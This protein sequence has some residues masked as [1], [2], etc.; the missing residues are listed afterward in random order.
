M[1]STSTQPAT[2]ECVDILGDIFDI[3]R[4]SIH[5]GPGIRTT[6]FFK[7]CPLSCKW[8]HNPESR[9]SARQLAFYATKCISCGR[10]ITA[11]S[12]EAIIQDSKRVDRAKCQ[13]CGSCAEACPAEALKMIGKKQSV[14]DVVKIVMRDLP[15]YKTSKGGAT[16]SGGEPTFQFDYLICLLKAFK[17]N[18]LHTAIETCGLTTR[19]KMAQVMEYCD[20]FLMDVKVIDSTKHKVLCG[21]DNAPILDMARFIAESPKEVIYRTPIVPGC[22][23]SEED[24]RQLGE[25]IKSLPGSRPLELMAYHKIGS[26]KYEA[27]GMEY[28]LPDVEA[29]DNIPALRETLRN[30]GVT[31]IGE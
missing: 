4:F 12:N 8:C 1:N 17:Q 2:P 15:F 28:P 13:V 21:V 30:M 18:G 31:V 10:C 16:V 14:E 19:D 29:P 20:M 6:V 5:D 11:C 26:G 9:G 22:N 3:Q 24:I 23:D 27:L 25:F 7:G